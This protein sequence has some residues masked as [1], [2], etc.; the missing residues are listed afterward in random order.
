MFTSCQRNVSLSR[1]AMSFVYVWHRAPGAL[2]GR[3]KMGTFRPPCHLIWNA[4]SAEEVQDVTLKN[5]SYTSSSSAVTVSLFLP[6]Y[7]SIPLL[8]LFSLL[9]FIPS[10]PPH[11]FPLMLLSAALLFPVT[12]LF[13]FPLLLH[14]PSHPSIPPPPLSPPPSCAVGSSEWRSSGELRLCQPGRKQCHEGPG[15]Q[16]LLLS[17]PPHLPLGTGSEQPSP[18]AE[19]A[20][21]SRLL[22]CNVAATGPD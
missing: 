4:A 10:C 18:L 19:A 13:I 22:L 1:S 21:R 20:P 8:L 3:K 16:G 6:R 5:T 12:L 15:Q 2:G 14:I 11:L 7:S 17:N 9:C